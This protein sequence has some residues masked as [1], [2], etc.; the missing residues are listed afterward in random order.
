MDE[1]IISLHLPSYTSQK[2]GKTEMNHRTVFHFVYFSSFSRSSP[3]FISLEMVKIRHP[4]LPVTLYAF[5]SRHYSPILRIS[6][7]D[8]TAL[9]REFIRR[10]CRIMV[11]PACHYLLLPIHPTTFQDCA[12]LFCPIDF[13]TFVHTRLHTGASY[14]D[15]LN[16]ALHLD[17][18]R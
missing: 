6:A 10:C 14:L 13:I 16:I 1:R 18:I 5:W 3:R 8:V 15:P 17:L 12:L 11:R 9:P 2:P 7:C 4:E